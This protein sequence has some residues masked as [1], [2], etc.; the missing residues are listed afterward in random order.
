MR[1]GFQVVDS[2]QL[3]EKGDYHLGSQ[4][5]GTHQCTFE[6]TYP[7]V[8][9]QLF[10]FLCCYMLLRIIVYLNNEAVAK[11]VALCLEKNNPN[12]QWI[13]AAQS[14]SR[15]THTS[16][17]QLKPSKDSASCEPFSTSCNGSSKDELPMPCEK[18]AALA[19]LCCAASPSAASA[20]C[21]Y[22]GFF[23]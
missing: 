13:Q 16:G 5:R 12:W 1:P 11:E 8:L 2:H 6:S 23:G 7:T 18:A 21:R 19:A 3:N 20:H 22:L 14:V 4:F 15:S 10:G 17:A 9:N